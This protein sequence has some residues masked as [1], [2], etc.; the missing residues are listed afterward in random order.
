MK[1][2]LM[3]SAAFGDDSVTGS[4]D[5][6]NRF[7]VLEA[8]IHPTKKQILKNILIKRHSQLLLNKFRSFLRHSPIG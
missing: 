1:F 7:D 5:N 3:V 8:T 4:M 6:K 2:D